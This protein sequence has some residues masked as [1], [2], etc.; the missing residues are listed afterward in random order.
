M[1]LT[2]DEKSSIER[3][4]NEYGQYYLSINP[5]Y[6]YVPYQQEEIVPALEALECGDIDRL[7]I[8]MHPGAA[9]SRL[10]TAGF[11]PWVFGRRPDREIIVVS[12]GDKPAS[13]FGQTIRD[14]LNSGFHHLVFPWCKLKGAAQATTYFQTTEG[15]KIHCA[16]WSGAI[17]STRA[18]F[19]LIDDPLKNY[20]EATSES[21]MDSRMRMFNSVVTDR[22]KPYGKI[23]ICTNRWAPRD[24]VGR[25]L[26][27][28]AKRWK[29]ITLPAEPRQ[30]DATFKYLAPGTQFLWENYFGKQKYIDKQTDQ[31]AWETTYQQRPERA[32]PVRFELDWIKYYEDRINPGQF[33]TGMVVD[34]ALAKHK[35]ADRTCVMVFGGGPNEK[36]FLVDCILDR[37]DPAERTRAVI[38]LADKW[39]VEWILW[40]EVGMSSDTFYLDREVEAYGLNCPV[41][42]V[43]RKGPR[44]NW[45]KHQRIMQLIPDFKEG[46]IVLPDKL[47]YK[48]RDGIS[49]DLM[50][51]F[52]KQEYLPY[53]GAN[54]IP[55]DE[56]LDTLSRIHEENFQLQYD[57]GVPQSDTEEEKREGGKF[58]GMAGGRGSWF[59]RL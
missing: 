40:E 2:A 1:D 17:V 20:E 42:P 19:V 32:L 9:K 37:L 44:H 43:G 10:C 34:P 45:S 54:S 21:V 33:H 59:A 55:H 22:L 25:I 46:R 5:G 31:W 49:V 12:Y 15:G 14:Q 47:I 53:A 38:K 13:E 57:E 18:D 48:Q 50:D 58:E 30:D 28:D 56:M 26:E 35:L 3:A 51:Y 29:V 16:C 7:M 27:N 4:R 41:I 6:D 39:E 36:I 11:A 52:L 8:L 24:V 23:V